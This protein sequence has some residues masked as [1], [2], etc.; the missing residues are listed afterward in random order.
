MIANHAPNVCRLVR[1]NYTSFSSSAA[2]ALFT[3]KQAFTIP[4]SII[5]QVDE[6]SEE[7][8]SVALDVGTG[9]GGMGAVSGVKAIVG[10]LL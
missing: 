1:Q 4:G 7:V 8:L 6:L 10:K 2:S 9:E 5:S 3:W